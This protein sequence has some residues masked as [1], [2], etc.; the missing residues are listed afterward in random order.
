M[1]R[2]VG[3]Q[4][5]LH[6][7]FP[8]A[9]T[10]D[11]TYRWQNPSVKD[12]CVHH[13]RADRWMFPFQAFHPVQD[14]PGGAVEHSPGAHEREK[15]YTSSSAE[16]RSARFS[17]VLVIGPITDYGDVERGLSSW[18]REIFIR[19]GGTWFAD[20]ARVIEPEKNRRR[21]RVSS[22]ATRIQVLSGQH[23]I[24]PG[25]TPVVPEPDMLAECPF[26]LH[27]ALFHHMGRRVVELI[28]LTVDAMECKFIEPERKKRP[29]DL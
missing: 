24:V 23:S 2:G 17:T 3:Q 10:E 16:F 14:H 12:T 6:G 5:V 19:G 22:P 13:K 1:E 20:T 27:P 8:R 29:E 7:F 21:E 18:R 25:R 15:V 28:A 4:S 9:G 11:R 26:E